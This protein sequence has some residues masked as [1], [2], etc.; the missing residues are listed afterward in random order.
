MRGGEREEEKGGEEKGKASLIHIVSF[1]PA[2]WQ[3]VF[4]LK[5]YDIEN[6]M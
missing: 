1:I 5:A 2:I 3:L 4:W 6:R